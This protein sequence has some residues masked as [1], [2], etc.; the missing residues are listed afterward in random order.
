MDEKNQAGDRGDGA[1]GVLIVEDHD[2]VAETLRRALDGEDDMHVVGVAG[3][4]ESAPE[5]PTA[6][7]A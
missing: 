6:V 4:V 7:T 5:R 2:L 3:S 1:I